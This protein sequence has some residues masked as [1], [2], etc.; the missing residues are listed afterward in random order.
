[1]Y[2]CPETDVWNKTVQKISTDFTKKTHIAYEQ[3]V[4]AVC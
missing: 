3:L 2:G 4:L 1:M